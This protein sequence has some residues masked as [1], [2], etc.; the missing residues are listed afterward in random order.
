M[1]P[2]ARLLF[3]QPYMQ[4][5]IGG[6]ALLV[7]LAGWWWA[8]REGTD[9]R[10]W[11]Y[12][13][14]IIAGLLAAGEVTQWVV[15]TDRERIAE[16]L[17]SAAVA[18]EKADADAV[19]SV[20]D[21]GLVADGRQREEFRQWLAATLRQ[22]KIRNPSVQKLELQFPTRNEASATVSAV[23]T[24]Q[25]PEYAGVVSGVWRM[26]FSRIDGQW[27]IVELEPAEGKRFP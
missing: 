7:A 11:T 19:L 4:A 27:K 10:G 26:E 1:E 3:E 14:G 9:A 16:L 17:N 12:A 22:V 18:L 15:V 2:I 23:A 20:T 24:I 5:V 13:L 21:A 25:S 8:R 6:A